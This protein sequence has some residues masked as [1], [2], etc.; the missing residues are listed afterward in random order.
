MLPLANSGKMC[1]NKILNTSTK[2]HFEDRFGEDAR[3][4][5]KDGHAGE[6]GGK[7]E[8]VGDCVSNFSEKNIF[9]RLCDQDVNNVFSEKK[10][11]SSHRVSKMS[12]YFLSL[13]S[14]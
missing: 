8:L 11:F 5:Q 3:R 10:V 7:E 9:L 1:E 4:R 6:E 12:Q 2:D 13:K 14:T